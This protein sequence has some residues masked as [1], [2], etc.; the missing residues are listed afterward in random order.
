MMNVYY[1]TVNLLDK[2]NHSNTYL[3]KH[4]KKQGRK[5]EDGAIP[6][7]Q[8]LNGIQEQCCGPRDIASRPEH[9]S[10]VPQL[11]PK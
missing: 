3:A 7:L 2:L 10:R 4:I 11:Q 6:G 8:I 9:G 1:W 5:L